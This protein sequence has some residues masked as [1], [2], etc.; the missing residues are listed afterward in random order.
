MRASRHPVTFQLL[1]NEL[2]ERHGAEVALKLLK[3]FLDAGYSDH[4]APSLYYDLINKSA[5][6]KSV[7]QD[8]PFIKVPRFLER[9]VK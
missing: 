3:G 4:V 6:I 2:A 7:S 1:M 8:M 9:C 5:G